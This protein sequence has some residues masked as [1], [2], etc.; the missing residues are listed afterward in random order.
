M[1]EAFCQL[2]VNLETNDVSSQLKFFFFSVFRNF[3][4]Q[5]SFVSLPHLGPLVKGTIK[6]RCSDEKLFFVLKVG[7][8]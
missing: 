7:Y 2:S 1:A 6:A 4:W 5:L 3:F 8:Y